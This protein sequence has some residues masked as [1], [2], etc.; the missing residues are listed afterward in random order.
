MFGGLIC[1]FAFSACGEADPVGGVGNSPA[2]PRNVEAFY[3]DQVIHLSWELDPSW[4]DEPFRFYAR[5]TTD[6]DY[7]LV[8]EV[9][10]CSGG[11]CFYRD[12]NISPN[13]TYEYLIVAVSP[14]TGTET[15][16]TSPVSVSVP[17]PLPPP[18]PGGL[19]AVALDEA[20]YLG[21]DDRSREAEDFAF[22][23]VY[24]AWE[25]DTVELLGETDSEGFLDLLVENGFT[26]GYFVTAVDAQGH[27][28]GGSELATGT[29]RPDFH[30]D[31]VYAF[32]DRPEFSG[33]RFQES[34]EHDPILPGDDPGRDFRFEVSG[35]DWSL[36]PGP[37]VE[38]HR[39]AIS[40]T[41]LRCGPAAD[42]GCTDV[43]LAPAADYSTDPIVLVA[44][45]S[46]VLRV[47]ADGGGWHY[48][49]IRVSHMG[50]AQDGAIAVFDWAF[51]LQP[52]NRALSPAE[53]DA[54]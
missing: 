20:I 10:S 40:T 34:E 7:F 35:D 15:S 31:F 41:M 36:V 14:R 37:G 53:T 47:P 50:F 25:D 29:P 19:E 8:A 17:E 6:P 43:P 28:S 18:V 42:A 33:F 21:W 30:G 11:W 24:I 13:L 32:G 38:V 23:R 44:G 16:A 27:E 51:Q 52:N 5:R 49:V 3:Y 26:Y 39:N 1:V 9:T 4:S 2:P 22:Y 45:R 48:G 46:F 54:S 12:P